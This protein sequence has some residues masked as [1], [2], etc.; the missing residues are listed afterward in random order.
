[1][2]NLEGLIVDALASAIESALASV[3]A[4]AT[5]KVERGM[6]V[7][8]VGDS[9]A[10]FALP[11]VVIE[12]GEGDEVDDKKILSETPD[13]QGN[14]IVV[15]RRAYLEDLPL[16]VWIY[17]KSK[18]ELS[19]ILA[20]IREIFYPSIDGEERDLELALGEGYGHRA[21]FIVNRQAQRNQNSASEGYATYLFTCMATAPIVVT[22]TEPILTIT[23]ETEAS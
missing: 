14:M 8:D 18:T 3:P 20:K 10:D 9:R 2:I 1:M 12:S 7:Q 11:S 23:L 5:G 22:R 17:A 13:G 4:F 6:P 19:S 15:K 16:Q 21:R